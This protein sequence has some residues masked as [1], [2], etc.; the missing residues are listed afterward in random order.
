MDG[1]RGH[2][3]EQAKPELRKTS[4]SYLCSY[5][6]LDLKWL[7]DMI[8]KWGREETVGGWWGAIWS[9]YTMSVWK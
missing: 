2:H 9:K 3:D 8:A 6:E 1:T 4:S 5:V 7:C